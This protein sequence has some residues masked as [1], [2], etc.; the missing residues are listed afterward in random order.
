MS[1]DGSELDVVD[2]SLSESASQGKSRS[3]REVEMEEP[4]SEHYAITRTKMEYLCLTPP[5]D[6][7]DDAEVHQVSTASTNSNTPVSVVEDLK[8]QVRDSNQS[9]V[10]YGQT[11]GR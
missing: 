5:L 10:L 3:R 4:Q 2:I 1:P 6:L 7:V 9:S 11:F 8:L